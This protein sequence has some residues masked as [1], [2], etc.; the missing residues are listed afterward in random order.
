MTHRRIT[1]VAITSLLAATLAASSLAGQGGAGQGGGGRA[2]GA[3]R[4]GGPAAPI[5]DTNAQTTVGSASIA[6]TV[7][8]EGAGTPVRRAR[9]SL[10]A[11]ELRGGRAAITDDQGRFSFA[12]LPA[13]RFT[14]TASKS[15]FV[16][17]SFGA[18]RAGRPGTPVQLAD[19]QTLER[20]TLAM[21]RG[22][23]LTGVVVDEHGEPSAGTQ[24][25]ALRYVM[26]TGERRLQMAGQDQT[27][28]RGMYRIFQLQP[29][30]YI[31]NAVPRN[32]GAND[33]RQVLAAEVANLTQQLQASGGEVSAAF[34]S[35]AAGR[36]GEIVTRIAQLQQQ[37]VTSEQEQSTAYAPV[38]FPGTASP[39]GAQSVTLAAGEER[40]GVDFQLRLVATTRISGIVTG[41]TGAPPA[42]TTVA[43]VPATGAG[44][45]SIPG[46]GN[47]TARVGA[48]G[49]FTFNSVTPGDYVLQARATVR[50][51]AA[52]A[53]AAPAV[54]GRGGRGGQGPI[55]QV[56]W[57]AVNL[58]VGGQP[59][60]DIVLTLQ[61]GMT[62][63]GQ[64]QFDGPGTPPA[65]LSDVRVNLT[66]R[67]PQTFE[68]GGTPPAQANAAGRFTLTGVA[69]GRYAL[70]ATLGGGGGGRAGGAGGRGLAGAAA[71]G[72]SSAWVLQSAMYNGQDLLDFPVDIG[73]NQSLQN[74]VVTY[75]SRVQELTGTIQDTSGRPTSDFTIIVFPSDAKYWMPQAR[76]ITATRPG[77]DGRFTFRGLP[78]GD[79]R[80]T[81]VTD[82]EPGEWYDPAFLTQLAGVSIPIALGAGERKVQDIRLAGG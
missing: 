43:L 35:A 36:G 68:I 12:A 3:G 48:E 73:P 67:G 32:V 15:G 63:S 17:I 24:V 54:G 60:P 31:I 49:R 5:R 29:G 33:M 9:V 55:S 11:P 64:V 8:I 46:L 47:S 39:E 69:P 13:G 74:V 38:Y 14:I 10:A 2:G 34:A 75:G 28:D 51:A 56:L 7:V 76:R 27:D 19:G 59:L 58:G 61:D 77:T 57:A 62:V 20:L 41:P 16:D 52:S 4:G 1:R 37:M 40:G 30:E 80:L 53:A 42:G 21:P 66:A 6:G 70:S 78:A 71:P 18:K 50:D 25:R 45:P 22:S 72:T 44:V 26:Q 81:A 65:D 82:V 23:V 79:Y